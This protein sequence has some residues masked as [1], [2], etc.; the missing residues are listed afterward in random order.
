MS[1]A[2][3]PIDLASL[4]EEFE[5]FCYADQWADS[6]AFRDVGRFTRQQKKRL[7]NTLIVVRSSAQ[8]LNRIEPQV[9]SVLD[10]ADSLA[11]VAH[12][13]LEHAEGIEA[14]RAAVVAEGSEREADVRAVADRNEAFATELEQQLTLVESG[15][16][17]LDAL[18]EEV[19]G[20]Q[21]E[22]A[23]L[24]DRLEGV[25][26]RLET[27][28]AR[29]DVDVI[30]T[31]VVAAH[32]ASGRRAER[33]EARLEETES[34]HAASYGRVERLEAHIERLESVLD[35]SAGVITGQQLE[36][37][38]CARKLDELE[39]QAKSRAAVLPRLLFAGGIALGLA[40]QAVWVLGIPGS[41]W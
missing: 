30:L 16:D 18:L 1:K 7:N 31:E 34:A 19:G 9:A 27:R 20:T 5:A 6:A 28:A 36:L 26:V 25:D 40:A 8:R 33:I 39:E 38:S 15:G 11:G 17:Q 14:L 32:D 21:R 12:T 23:S 2:E 4:P 22:I 37:E 35:K 24:G 10:L 3:K 29:S 41:I 13:Q